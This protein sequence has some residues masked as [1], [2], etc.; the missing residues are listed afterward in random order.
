MRFFLM[1]SMAV[2]A[3]LHAGVTVIT[4]GDFQP[5]NWSQVVFNQ[6]NGTGTNSRQAAGGNPDA[7]RQMAMA[8]QPVAAGTNL[9]INIASFG[10]LLTYDPSAG[11]AIQQIRFDYDLSRISSTGLG[12]T[13]PA[14]FYRPFLEQGG[15]RFFLAGVDDQVLLS[16][17]TAFHHVSTDPNDWGQINAGV[18][19]PDFSASGGV[20]TF[21]Y[22][23][24][25]PLI[26]PAGVTSGCLAAAAVSGIDNFKVTVTSADPAGTVPEPSAG[27]LVGLGAIAATLW[28]K[29]GLG[30]RSSR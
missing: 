12:S 11:G 5:A 1:L 27:A 9:N 29:R 6:V 19:K 17:W 4:D 16:A 14:G 25:L 21:G 8:F 22:R 13:T 28:R 20:I 30:L 15:K 24:A 26:C 3:P 23:V 7:Y 10:S 18:E 2:Y